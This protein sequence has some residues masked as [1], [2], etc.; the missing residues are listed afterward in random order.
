LPVHSAAIPTPPVIPTLPS[1]TRIRRWVRLAIRLI[2][3][4]FN[5]RNR[6][7]STPATRISLTS[8]R[9]ICTAPSASRITLQATPSRALSRI[10]AA[11]SPAISPRQ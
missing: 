6:I 9:F 7:T 8:E 5:G 11:T 4:G 10:A 3:Y 2:A 1:A